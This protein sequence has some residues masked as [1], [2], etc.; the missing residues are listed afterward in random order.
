MRITENIWNNPKLDAIDDPAAGWVYVVSICLCSAALSDGHFSPRSAVRRA[1]V[2]QSLA[3]ALVE[4][5]LW[6]LPGHTCPRCP[7]PARGQAYVHDY[8]L[9]QR[10]RAE[11]LDLTRKRREAGRL[12]AAARWGTKP[13][14]ASAM[15][16]AIE[17]DG[18]PMAEKRRG[19]ETPP[20]PPSVDAGRPSWV[21]QLVA[22]VLAIREDWTA[23]AVTRALRRPQV[24]DRPPELVARTMLL[25][26]TDE[27][28]DRPSR[29][30]ANHGFW[31]Q[32]RRELV[33]AEAGARRRRVS[34][35]P[36]HLP[37]D[38]DA[39]GCARCP[40]PVTHPVHDNPE[41]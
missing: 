13:P 5:G 10:S 28:T 3:E 4:Q 24:R 18:I 25:L 34:P 19:E 11:V 32:A 38:D 26:A 9:H 40:L 41:D 33:A 39:G 14:K 6:H 8:L 31:A 2:D 12:G 1:G 22:D 17:N 16:D 21:E 37:V 7:Q 35:V 29:L 20:P 15:A 23:E 36:P 27:A 30:S